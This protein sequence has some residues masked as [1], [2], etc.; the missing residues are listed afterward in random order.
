MSFKEFS[1]RGDLT[2]AGFPAQDETAPGPVLG[3]WTGLG[4]SGDISSWLGSERSPRLRYLTLNDPTRPIRDAWMAVVFGDVEQHAYSD[5]GTSYLSVAAT[6]FDGL[7]AGGND[8]RRLG[9]IVRG[10]NA[11]LAR[12][13]K[14]ALVSNGNTQRRAQ[15]INA[16]FDDVFD[17]DR[18]HPHEAQSRVVAIWRR[19]L[20]RFERE[21]IEFH[22]EA[23]LARV[24]N[25]HSLTNRERRLLLLLL[26][27]D[28]N[29]ATYSVIKRE[30]SNYHEDISDAYLKV[31]VCVVRRKLMPGVRIVARALKGY[32]LEF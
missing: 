23:L 29:F 4:A 16:G 22:N 31:I 25:P 13:I 9:R 30:I 19:Y 12:R 24:C 1:Q 17:A 26:S 2:R 32:R 20:M 5:N 21:R 3:D 7:V 11:L 18:T 28:Q 15:L 6:G 8:V 27:S 10:G 14:I